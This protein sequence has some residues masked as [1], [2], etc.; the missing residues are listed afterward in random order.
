MPKNALKL[1]FL[2]TSQM[3]APKLGHASRRILTVLRAI[4]TFSHPH[5]KSDGPYPKPILN[6]ISDGAGFASFAFKIRE[7][8]F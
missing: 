8:R 6:K 4:S 2:K 3:A 1:I 5:P 7:I